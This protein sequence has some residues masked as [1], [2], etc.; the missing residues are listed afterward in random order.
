MAAAADPIGSKAQTY[1]LHHRISWEIHFPHK[2]I[3][4]CIY[5]AIVFGRR[6]LLCQ[7]IVLRLTHYAGKQ[8][9]RPWNESQCVCVFLESNSEQVCPTCSLFGFRRRRRRGLLQ[10]IMGREEE[11]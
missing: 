5:S 8:R 11:S 3:E 6:L 2:S 7:G 10:N 9:R 4:Y 1:L